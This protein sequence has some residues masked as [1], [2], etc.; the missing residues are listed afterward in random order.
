MYYRPRE[1]KRSPLVTI[2]LILLLGIMTTVLLGLLAIYIGYVDIQPPTLA[3]QFA[4]TATPTRSPILYIGDGDQYFADGKL[5]QAIDAY[6]EAIQRDPSDDIPYI[7]QS[8]LL[9]YTRET[10]KAAERA[11]QAVVINP[12]SSENLAYYCRALDWEARYAEALDA[13]SCAIEMDPDYAEG[14]AF[15]SEIYADL[16]NWRLAQDNAQRALDTNFQSVDAHH[17][18]GYALEVQGR[19]GQAVE[20]YEN[21][22]K[23]APNLAS[24]YIDAGRIYHNGLADYETAAERF[25][26]AIKLSPFDPEGY[27]LLGWAYY[28]NGE[29]VRAID[30]FEQSIGLDPTYVNPYRR[31]SAWGHL[32]TLYYTRQNFE[33]AVEFLP[34]AIELGES[35]FLRRARQVEILTE[36]ETLTGPKSIPVLRGHFGRT[37]TLDYIAQL[38]PVNYIS[39]LEFETDQACGELIKQSIQN[40]SVLL[41]STELISFTQVYSPA[42]GTAR[43]EPISDALFL[44]LHNL[45]QPQ[46]TPYEIQITFW[47]DRTDSVGFFQPDAGQRAQVNIQFEEKL[48]APIEYYYTLGLAY[49][50][51]GQCR[52]AVPWLLKALQIDSSGYNPAWA[53]LRDC[54]SADSPPTPIPTPTPLPES[55]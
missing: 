13:C 25:K 52:D 5:Q 46:T 18:M 27:D 39:E 48:K 8:R 11:T 38:E 2:L 30:A 12:Q 37:D 3:E 51:L 36:L 24:L 1:K 17:N 42:T 53:G 31:E 14:Y 29:Y 4:P 35:E 44:D 55:E 9:I 19:Y 45:P 40:E 6:E 47:P 23:L 33:Q 28:F 7:R 34:K 16:G 43:L 15:L 50:Y 22:I 20:F 41:S 10:A 21:A 49:T 32:G 54:P 26:K